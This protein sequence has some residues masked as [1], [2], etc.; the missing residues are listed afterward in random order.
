MVWF[1]A[2]YLSSLKELVAV[3]GNM[4]SEEKRMAADGRGTLGILHLNQ[5]IEGEIVQ[6]KMA[7]MFYRGEGS[8]PSP[9]MVHRVKSI[10]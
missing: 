7:L 4:D 1:V 5:D 2:E 3:C 9:S 10:S 6:I 8:V